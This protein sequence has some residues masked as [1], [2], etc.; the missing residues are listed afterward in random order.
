MRHLHGPSVGGWI[1][2]IYGSLVF[3]S[4]VEGLIGSGEGLTSARYTSPVVFTAALALSLLIWV[5]LSARNHH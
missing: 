1:V 3:G 5:G 4:L 2:I